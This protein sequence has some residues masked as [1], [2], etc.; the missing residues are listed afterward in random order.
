MTAL[1][2]TKTATVGRKAKT[3][4]F[5]DDI[6]VNEWEQRP[7][8][9][10]PVIRAEFDDIFATINLLK[11][12]YI[13]EEGIEEANSI[14]SENDF[15]NPIALF[16]RS[17][18]FDEYGNCKSLKDIE[19]SDVLSFMLKL[20]TAPIPVTEK[21][22][23]APPVVIIDRNGQSLPNAGLKRKNTR[24]HPNI[25][26]MFDRIV[27]EFDSLR[28]AYATAHNLN[29]ESSRAYSQTNYFNGIIQYIY[30]L[31]INE[32]KTEKT[33]SEIKAED[34]KL[35]IYLLETAVLGF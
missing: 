32:D 5:Q 15:H 18:I 14:Y 8:R 28:K 12:H 25:L 9:L 17:E 13:R 10:H 34:N 20:A 26:A 1:A 23:G 31:F 6:P 35:A 29:I 11:R 4:S 16:L 33:L 24:Y 19:K 22:R 27:S 2:E 7:V 21:K 30:P 3:T